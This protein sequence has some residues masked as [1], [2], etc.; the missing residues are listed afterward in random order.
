M[1]GI[2]ESSDS[3]ISEGIST[4]AMGQALV[5]TQLGSTTT[6]RQADRAQ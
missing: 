5:T 6:Y 1:K 2:D 3:L 4:H